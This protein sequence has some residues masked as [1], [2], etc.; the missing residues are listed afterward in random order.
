VGLGVCQPPPEK[1]IVLSALQA[2]PARSNPSVAENTLR[3]MPDHL[4][5]LLVP[6]CWWIGLN[7]T[8][9]TYLQ[10]PPCKTYRQDLNVKLFYDFPSRPAFGPRH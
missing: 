3:I 8:C 6:H 1:A 9:K 7:I 5:N 4:T 10:D 2:R